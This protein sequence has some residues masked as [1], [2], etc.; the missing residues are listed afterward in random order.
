MEFRFTYVATVELIEGDVPA[1][2]A[3]VTVAL[4]GHWEHEG[5]CRWPHLTTTNADA[6]SIVVTV[7]FTCPDGERADVEARI[8][9]ALRSGLLAGPDEKVTK[10]R[11]VSPR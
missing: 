3:A 2:G 6:R 5:P 1:I 10:W 4:C 11:V 9:R 8:A 7:A